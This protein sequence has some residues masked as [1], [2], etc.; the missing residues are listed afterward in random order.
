MH[1][2]NYVHMH[3]YIH[4]HNCTYIHIQGGSKQNVPPDKMRYLRNRLNFFC[5]NF[6]SCRGMNFQQTLK[7]SREIF[8]SAKATAVQ[9][10]NSVFS[11]IRGKIN[12]TCWFPCQ[13]I[14]LFTTTSE[15][16]FAVYCKVW[17][18]C[19]F[20][21]LTRAHII[22]VKFSM[23]LLIGSCCN[24]SHINSKT[25]QSSPTLNENVLKHSSITPQT[26]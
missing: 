13:M 22:F 11:N 2:Y 6:P 1:I 14:S 4:I 18:E 7:V 5:E 9:T 3:T 12:V 26:W 8:M 23:V 25:G 16:R 19:P 20:P 10:C 24:W 21:A 15:F 17:W